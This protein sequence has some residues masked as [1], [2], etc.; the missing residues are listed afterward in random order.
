MCAGLVFLAIGQFLFASLLLFESKGLT[1]ALALFAR[2][3][4]GFG[5]SFYFTPLYS[6][7]PE[8]YPKQIESKMSFATS[9][10]SIGYLIGPGCGSLLYGIGG[11]IGPFLFFGSVAL[12]AAF[13]L[14]FVA[15][16]QSPF[17]K[18]R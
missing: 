17:Q 5:F 9:M 2:F 14:P 1:I 8:L 12:L 4:N 11:F 7:I 16:T 10:N 6:L 15:K 3:I 18:V 13:I